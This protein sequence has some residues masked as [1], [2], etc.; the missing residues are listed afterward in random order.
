MISSTQT[1]V[2]DSV[3]ATTPCAHAEGHSFCAPAI[4]LPARLY[5]ACALTLVITLVMEK[6]KK[7]CNTK[8]HFRSRSLK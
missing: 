8:S 7:R 6:S 2:Y 1:P 5:Y 3:L 4:R